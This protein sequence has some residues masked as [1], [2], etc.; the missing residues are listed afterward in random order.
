MRGIVNTRKESAKEETVKTVE[1][2]TAEA[3]AESKYSANETDRA[4][5]TKCIAAKKRSSTIL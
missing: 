4:N 3:I 5:S 1:T 2:E